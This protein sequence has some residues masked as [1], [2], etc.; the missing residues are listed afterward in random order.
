M[1]SR[2]MSY[3]L[4]LM[5]PC[6]MAQT[7]E[8]DRQREY[9]RQ[10]DQQREEQ[11]RRA[12]EEYQRQLRSTEDARKKTEQQYDDERR[13]ANA[14]P[15]SSS[16]DARGAAELQAL[17]A[18]LL[19]MPPL[20]DERNTLLGRW[21]V[22]SD[23]KPKRKD[24]LGQRWPCWLTPAA[25]PASSRSGMASSNSSR[26]PG[27]A[28][29]GYGDD[30]LGP[31]AYRADGK[32]LF[33]LPAKGI[34]IMGFDV[35]NPNRIEVFNLAGCALNR[36]TGTTTTTQSGLSNRAPSASAAGAPP[37]APGPAKSSTAP[38]VAAVAPARAA[39]NAVAPVARSLPQQS[40]STS[41]AL[42]ASTRC[43]RCPTCAS[44]N[45][46][47]KARC[48]T[49]TTC[50]STCAA[51][52]ATTRASR[53]RCTTST[54]MK[55]CS[56]SR[57]SGIARPGRRRRRSSGAC[58]DAVARPSR[59]PPPQSPGRLQADTLM[60]RLI[61]QDMPERNLLLEAYKAKK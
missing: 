40:S 58:A 5:V 42:S 19:R 60:G 55:C 43:G 20:P 15:A 53:R 51:A 29:M 18:K 6:A 32:R 23:G 17:R 39:V 4:A 25:P 54:R 11:Q 26:K 14:R 3:V 16:Y 13:S 41:S 50:A 36:V 22:E 9:Y 8:A 57:S 7:P 47:S 49:R 45:P 56:R 38:Q 10:L 27:P 48:R 44:R 61:L 35:V 12:Q 59:L 28:S 34:E 30:S 46:R 33:A 37:P 31:I 1:L 2:F 24:E 21:R 52:P